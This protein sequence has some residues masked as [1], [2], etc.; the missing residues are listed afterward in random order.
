M[1]LLQTSSQ[2]EHFNSLLTVCG[3]PAGWGAT[4]KKQGR[5]ESARPCCI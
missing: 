2:P 1:R 4:Y 5:T 3:P